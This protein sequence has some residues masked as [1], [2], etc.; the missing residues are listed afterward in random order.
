MRCRNSIVT[1]AALLTGAPAAAGVVLHEVQTGESGNARQSRTEM[2]LSAEGDGMRSDIIESDFPLT[3]RGSY[4]LFPSDELIYLVNPANKTYMSMDLGLM[5]GISQQA[6][7]MQHQMGGQGASASADNLVIEK[8]VEEAGPV[9]LGLPTRHVVYE[10]SYRRPSPVQMQGIMGPTE[11]HEKYEIW[12]T[13]ALDARFAGVPVL[14]RAANRL[15]DMGGMPELK[16]VNDAIASH[17][18]ILKKNVTMESKMSG[19][20]GSPVSMFMRPGAQKRTSSSV[21]TAIRDETLQPQR[22]MLPQGYAEVA[23]MNPNM[24]AMPDLSKLPGRPGAPQQPGGPQQPGN[25]PPQMPDLN[26]IPK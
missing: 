8:K 2:E 11:V 18:F 19:G 10:V 7:R 21:V 25:T 13:R 4:M 22:F 5:A 16:E 9:M 15:S 17:G 20:M 1:V 12:A 26:N 24:G 23:M 14:K 6:Q 3:P